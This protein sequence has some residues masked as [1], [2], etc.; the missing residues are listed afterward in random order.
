MI[1]KNI[2]SKN[3]EQVFIRNSADIV[4]NS[5]DGTTYLLIPVHMRIKGN[6]V[7]VR[8]AGEATKR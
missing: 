4:E 6:E 8:C 1:P 7:A 2:A 3:T 5:N